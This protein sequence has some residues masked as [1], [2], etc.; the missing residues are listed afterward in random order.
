MCIYHP[1]C[2]PTAGKGTD[3]K[4]CRACSER[5]SKI[6]KDVPL[7]NERTRRDVDIILATGILI[8]CLTFDIRLRGWPADPYLIVMLIHCC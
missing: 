2:S 4:A 8:C 1:F 6:V 7:L 5:S 3:W